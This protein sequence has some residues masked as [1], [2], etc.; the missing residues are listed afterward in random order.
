MA[1]WDGEEGEKRRRKTGE[2]GDPFPSILLPSS[3][4]H[5]FFV[6]ILSERGPSGCN[7]QRE[8]IRPQLKIRNYFYSS[9]SDR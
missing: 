9:S 6:R 3:R 7:L 5:G 2:V 1:E 8:D 4:V